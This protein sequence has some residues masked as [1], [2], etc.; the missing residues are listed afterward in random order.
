MPIITLCNLKGGT[1]K[2][3]SAIYIATTLTLQSQPVTV[4]DADPQGSATEWAQQ[5]EDTGNPLPFDIIP[6]NARSITRVKASPKEWIIID[7]P[8]GETGIIDAAIQAA[9]HVI[10]PTRPSTIEVNRMWSTTDLAG[11]TPV[12]VLIT[13]VIPNTTSL[14]ELGEALEEENIST[15]KIGI[16]QRE[17]IKKTFG[18]VPTKLHGYE[19]I[20]TELIKEMN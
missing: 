11:S 18:K 4:L 8:P 15:F 20:L 13:S 6:A 16:P 9:D 2:T 7:C 19:T 17:A 12:T 14:Q 5:A 1:G 10:I 3:T